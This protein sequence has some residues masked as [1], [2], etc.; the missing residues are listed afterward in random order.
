MQEASSG[1][2]PVSQ[3]VAGTTPQPSKSVSDAVTPAARAAAAGDVSG[4]PSSPSLTGLTAD[5]SIELLAKALV[6][7]MDD[8]EGL[9]GL[10]DKQLLINAQVISAMED[11]KEFHLW[12]ERHMRVEHS[13]RAY[14]TYRDDR[15]R[16]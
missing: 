4:V 9:R 15:T 13:T 5:Q 16:L 14:R 10:L 3:S 7:L 12:I 6:A 1:R 11:W 8:V 2:P